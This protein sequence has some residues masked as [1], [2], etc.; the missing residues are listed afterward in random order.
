MI[1]SRSDV[2]F[3]LTNTKPEQAEEK[4]HEFGAVE[5]SNILEAVVKAASLEAFG[6]CFGWK[7]KIREKL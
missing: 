7:S 5:K 4:L 3:V 2:L 6:Q 1:N